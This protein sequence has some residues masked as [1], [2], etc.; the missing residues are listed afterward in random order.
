M[1][2]LKEQKDA[3]IKLLKE[4]ELNIQFLD[5]NEIDYYNELEKIRLIKENIKLITNLNG[6][7]IRVL[8]QEL[9]ITN[10]LIIEGHRL[11]NERMD[12]LENKKSV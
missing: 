1:T 7:D 2:S 8:F 6:P 10:E 3:Y 11:I 9:I 5:V 12:K 4:K